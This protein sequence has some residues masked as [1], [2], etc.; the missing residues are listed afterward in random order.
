MKPRTHKRL[1]KAW[2]LCCG[3]V[4]GGLFGGLTGSLAFFAL[5]GGIAWGVFHVLAASELFGPW[6]PAGAADADNVDWEDSL[7]DEG[8]SFLDKSSLERMQ[9]DFIN[10]PGYYYMAGNIHN[11]D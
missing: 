2:P 9:D 10:N 1:L 4:I 8:K 3:L 6:A 11:D 5:F 7:L